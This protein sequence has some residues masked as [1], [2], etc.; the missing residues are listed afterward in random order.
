MPL[1]VCNL[2]KVCDTY[3]PQGDGNIRRILN[4]FQS[5]RF[6]IPIPRKGTETVFD[7]DSFPFPLHVCDT[8]SPQG[9][10]N[11]STRIIVYLL[12]VCDT[13]SPQGDGNISSFMA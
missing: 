11:F 5:L 12:E 3:S 7:A 8:Y 2:A 9:D 4:C 10:G 1:A 13:Y 6:V